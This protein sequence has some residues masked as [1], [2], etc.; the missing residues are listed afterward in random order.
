MNYYRIEGHLINLDNVA[1]IDYE[2]NSAKKGDLDLYD[3]TFKYVNGDSDLYLLYQDKLRELMDVCDTR[4]EL[5]T[6]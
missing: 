6:K 2:K 5:D 3:V 4:I 1:R